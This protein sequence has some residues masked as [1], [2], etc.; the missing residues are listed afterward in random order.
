MNTKFLTFFLILA[1][2]I[3]SIMGYF[4]YDTYKKKNVAENQINTLSNEIQ[5]LYNSNTS[6]ND[7]NSNNTIVSSPKTSNQASNVNLDNLEKLLDKYLT[8]YALSIDGT[9]LLCSYDSTE[10]YGLA[11]YNTYE[12]MEKD[13]TETK[14]FVEIDGFKNIL[15]KTSINFST[16]KNAM[17][18]YISEELF[19]KQFTT[20]HKNINGLLY[21]THNPGDGKSYDIKNMEQISSTDNSYTYKVSYHYYVGESKPIVG[22]LTVT[23]EKNS[24]NDYIIAK[25]NF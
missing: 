5:H 7:T 17:L 19:E 16:Y 8:L 3:I 14:E 22:T 15:Y 12:E 23:F 13:L 20:Y 11:L 10:I 6:S 1:I 24:N 4:L 2:I 18:K 9:P 21:V 25:C